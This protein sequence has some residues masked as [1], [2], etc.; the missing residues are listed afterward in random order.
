MG[1]Q[2]KKN[3]LKEIL[4]KCQTSSEI[5]NLTESKCAKIQTYLQGYIHRVGEAKDLG[6]TIFQRFILRYM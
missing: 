4:P 3:Q 2:S 6:P 1:H 5:L